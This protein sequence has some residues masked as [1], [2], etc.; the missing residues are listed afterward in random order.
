MADFSQAVAKTE[1][2]EGGYANN[3]HDSGGET[4]R[5]VSRNNWPNWAGWHIVDLLKAQTNFPKSLDI[6]SELQGMVIDFYHKNFWNYDGIIDQDVAW[7]VF[8]LGVNVGKVHAVKILQRAVGVNTDGVYG[9]ATESATNR[10]PY[11]SLT[12]VLRIAAENYHKEIVAIHP[13]DAGF[14]NGW[15]RRDDA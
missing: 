13:E 15:L 10:H 5:G 2:W 3:P 7:K 12:P 14:L 4:Y 9:P 6:D 11:G 1:L 8:D